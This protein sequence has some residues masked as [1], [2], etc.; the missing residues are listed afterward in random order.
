MR[1]RIGPIDRTD[2]PAVDEE[3]FEEPETVPGG[4]DGSWG[5]VS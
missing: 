3:A 1:Y 2:P 5:I 4:P